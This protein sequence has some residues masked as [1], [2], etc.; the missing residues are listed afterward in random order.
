M[1]NEEDPESGGMEMTMKRF[2]SEGEARNRLARL[3]LPRPFVVRRPSTSRESVSKEGRRPRSI[4]RT[5]GT[6]I[7]RVP[8]GISGTDAAVGGT[9]IA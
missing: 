2:V 9:R 4:P 3:G 5:K 7:F 6:E 1:Q 8:R